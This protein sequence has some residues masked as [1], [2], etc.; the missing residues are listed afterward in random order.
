MNR[1]P[2]T[3]ILR[4]NGFYIFIQRYIDGD[5]L[6]VVHDLEIPNDRIAR[7]RREIPVLDADGQPRTLDDMLTEAAELILA[8]IKSLNDEE[9]KIITN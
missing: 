5:R 7:F 9:K 1:T 6:V 3:A 8:E 2:L 4:D